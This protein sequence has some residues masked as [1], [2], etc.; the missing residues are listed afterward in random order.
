MEF[1]IKDPALAKEGKN[2]IDWAEAHMPVLV[3]LREKYEKTKPLK[4]IRVAGCLH[5]TK[6]TGVLVRT[7]KAAGAELSWCGCN[8]LS[9]QDDVAASLAQDEGISIFASRGVT[10]Q[11]YYDDIR[12]AMMIEPHVTID[13]GADL[14]V[15]MHKKNSN[16][17]KGGTEETT[18]GVIRL[19]AMQKAGK[20]MYPII[21]VNDAET[22]HDFDNIYGTG[23]SAL[24]GIIRATNILFAGKNVVV[25]GYGHVGKGISRRAAGLGA[26]VIV[27]EV[28]PIAALKAKMD[29]YTVTKMEKA[30]EIGDVFIT[31]TGCKDVII[32]KDIAKMKDGAI[33]A[34]AGH[35]NVEISIPA[36]E[37]QTVH[38]N[39]INENIMQYVLKN[40]SRI[41]LLG[42]GRLV[43]LAAAEGH[44]SEVMDMSFAN[45]FLSVIKLAKQGDTMKPLV[46]DID[47]SQDQEI[48]L[49]K[50]QAMNIEIDSLTPPQKVYLEGFNEGT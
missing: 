47:R 2:R 45:Q 35:F 48:A 40:G 29:G 19:R 28:D 36:I 31:T 7:L 14:T 1:R 39:K 34:N 49:A 8:P 24:D 23:Q 5:V 22:K 41:Y 44:P 27:T 6:E 33:L 20:L 17:I 21:A 38:Q 26:N 4:E 11:E 25:A 16:S 15:E 30:A 3:A 37:K 43:N 9:T 18:T 12:S 13:D 42:E 46:Y 32:D 10:Q 50:L